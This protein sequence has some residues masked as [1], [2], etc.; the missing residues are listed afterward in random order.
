[1]T[2]RTERKFQGISKTYVTAGVI[3]VDIPIEMFIQEYEFQ[4]SKGFSSAQALDNCK[5][6]CIGEFVSVAHQIPVGA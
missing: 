5:S 6:L 4:K 2:V 1:M 3:Y